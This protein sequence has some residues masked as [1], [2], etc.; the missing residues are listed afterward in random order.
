MSQVVPGTR[1]PR[2]KGFGPQAAPGHPLLLAVIVPRPFLCSSDMF[3]HFYCVDPR[4]GPTWVPLGPGLQP[5]PA[6]RAGPSLSAASRPLPSHLWRAPGARKDKEPPS[7]APQS[8]RNTHTVLPPKRS[9]GRWR[10]EPT[11][12]GRPGRTLTP[13]GARPISVSH[14]H[15]Q[16]SPGRRSGRVGVLPLGGAGPRTLGL[17]LPPS[18]R[19]PRVAAWPLQAHKGFRVL[20]VKE[21]A[22]RARRPSGRTGPGGEMGS[23]VG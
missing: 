3:G 19:P 12:T 1:R 4:K 17:H 20:K 8:P 9:H 7:E 6:P 10:R 16:P 21:A 14:P 2:A 13:R 11:E 5:G 15:A 23:L 22:G 18:P